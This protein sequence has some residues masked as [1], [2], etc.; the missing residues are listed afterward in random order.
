MAEIKK[1]KTPA[2]RAVFIHANRTAN[3]GHTHSNESIDLDRTKYNYRLKTGGIKDWQKRLDEVFR[4]RRKDFGD[5][6]IIYATVHKDEITPHMHLG[7]LPVQKKD[8]VYE[9]YKNQAQRHDLDLWMKKHDEL[10]HE[11]LL[12]SAII[13]RAYLNTMHERL[14]IHVDNYLGYHASVINGATVKGNKTV[15]ELKVKSLREEEQSLQK[16]IGGI[17]EDARKIFEK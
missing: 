7:F 14:Q 9:D 17:R 8:I 13:N 15:L 2:V 5:E 11:R 3:D 12:A 16:S 6:N 10:P 1:F 4:I